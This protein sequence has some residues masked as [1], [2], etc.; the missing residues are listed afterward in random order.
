MR[1]RWYPYRTFTLLRSD[2]DLQD[3]KDAPPCTLDPYSESFQDHYEADLRSALAL[4]E[5]QLV[6][7]LADTDTAS[8]ERVH[9]E[10]QRRAKFK[11][12]THPNDLTSLSSWFVARSHGRQQA[13]FD[14]CRG[15][16]TAAGGD[17]PVSAGPGASGPAEKKQRGGGGGA[18]R[19]FV[20]LRSSSQKLTAE[21]S[22]ALGAEY[23]ALTEEEKVSFRKFGGDCY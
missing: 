17:T 21:F 20:S 4:Q 14:R 19:A 2:D 22:A 12:W 9:S 5:L 16:E 11:V 23:S 15:K 6:A 3:L 10:N 7:Q 18:W 1:H 13:Y 8:T